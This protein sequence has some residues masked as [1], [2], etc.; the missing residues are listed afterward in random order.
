MVDNYNL[1]LRWAVNKI[2]LT[3]LMATLIFSRDFNRTS[4]DGILNRTM[5]TVR[6]ACVTTLSTADMASR[7]VVGTGSVESVV[8]NIWGFMRTTC[9]GD[10]ALNWAFVRAADTASK[11]KP[12]ASVW[13]T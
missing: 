1:R 4:T 2:I 9:V 12:R 5:A 3:S 10:M 6:S 13:S 11:T 7:A 8:V